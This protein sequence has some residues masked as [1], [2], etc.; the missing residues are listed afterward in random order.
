MDLVNATLKDL[1]T[2]RPDLVA[3]IKTGKDENISTTNIIKDAKG[4]MKIWTEETKDINNKLISKR[5]DSYAYYKTGELDTIIQE[6]YDNK[7]LVDKKEIKHY[8]NKQP[9]VTSV[10]CII[11]K[12]EEAL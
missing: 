11:Q 8:K 2:K 9:Q 10:E 12:I 4:R 3:D 6:K 5:V 1:I 7:N